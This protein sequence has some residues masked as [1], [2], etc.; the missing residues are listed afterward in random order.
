MNAFRS[1]GE[2]GAYGGGFLRFQETPLKT[3][4]TNKILYSLRLDTGNKVK[5]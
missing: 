5:F 1:D 4:K 2:A 3:T